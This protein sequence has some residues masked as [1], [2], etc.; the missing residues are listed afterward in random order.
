MLRLNQLSPPVGSTKKRK[1]IGRGAGSGHGGTATRGNKGQQSRSGGKSHPWFEGGQ[2]PLLR[3]LPKRGFKSFS[4]IEIQIVNLDSLEKCA[5]QE[6]ILPL[7]LKNAGLIKF[8]DRPV[9]ILGK[10]EVKS[11][12]TVQAHAYSKSALRKI[13]AAGGKAELIR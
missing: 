1:R 7:T 5:S 11:A 12:L 3:R 10:G 13:Q 2:M 9:K 6:T 8:A 4:K